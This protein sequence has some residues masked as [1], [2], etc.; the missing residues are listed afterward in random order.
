MNSKKINQHKLLSFVQERLSNQ[1]NMVKINGI[2]FTQ[3]CTS[4]IEASK[5]LHDG[6]SLN[7]LSNYS[8]PI[9]EKTFTL[10]NKRSITKSKTVASEELNIFYNS[11]FCEFDENPL[12]EDHCCDFV[13]AQC[14]V[15]FSEAYSNPVLYFQP[16]K[17][18]GEMLNLEECW[19][20]TNSFQSLCNNKKLDW[21][22]I[23]QAM[24]PVLN[25]PLY[26]LHPCHTSDFMEPVDRS[27]NYVM[28]WLSICLLPLGLDFTPEHY[29]LYFTKTCKKIQSKELVTTNSCY[30]EE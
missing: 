23:T 29:E 6:W 15:F 9:L 5:Y 12:C 28:S 18:S 3:A 21:S 10:K 25:Y 27:T 20:L 17:S 8:F 16:C 2:S 4:F 24:H 30:T 14:Q 13:T 1:S 11:E 22:F 26:Q 7:K 19:N